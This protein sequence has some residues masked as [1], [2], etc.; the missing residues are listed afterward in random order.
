MHYSGLL[1]MCRPSTVE[2]CAHDLAGCPGVD[3]Y[4]ADNASG[5]VVVVLETEDLESQRLG[6]R[7]IQDLPGVMAA[8]LVYHYFGDSK[9]E[10]EE[11]K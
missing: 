11:N 8:E 6:L 10:P 3:V 4:V 2:S 9:D 5:R 1:V 7:R